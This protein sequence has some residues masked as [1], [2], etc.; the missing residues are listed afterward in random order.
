MPVNCRLAAIMSVA[1][2]IQA[3][4]PDLIN[5]KTHQQLEGELAERDKGMGAHVIN[6]IKFPCFVSRSNLEALRTFEVRDDDVYVFSYPRSGTHWMSEILHYILHDGK[7]DFNRSFMTNALEMTMAE[8]PTQLESVTPGYKMYAAMA[9]PR[10]I[11]SHCLESFRPPQILTKQ[12]KVVYVARNPKD[13]LVSLSNMTSDWKFDE[14]FWA[15]CKEKMLMGS[16][17]DHVLSYW[18]QRDKEHFLFVKYEDLHKDLRGSICKLAKHVGKDLSDDVIDD[19]L[20]RVTFGGMQKTY[21]QLEEER[22]EEGQRMTRYQGNPHLRRGKVGNWKNTFTVAQSALFDK[23]YALR[24]EGTGLDFDF[25][26]H[27][28]GVRRL[29]ATMS[30]A[31]RIQALMPDLI[32]GKTHQQLEEELAVS[33]KQTGCHVVNGTKFPWTISRSNLEALRTFEVRND[34]VYVFT[35]PRSGTHWVCEILQCIL[36]DV[37]GDFDRTF[38]TNALEMTMTDDPTHLESVAPGYKAYAGMASPRCIF[39]HCLDSFRPPQIL[40]KRAKVVYVARNPK[41]M[42]VSLFEMGAHWKFD[43]MFWAFCH[44]K[45][46]LGSWFDHVLNHRDKENFQFIKYEDLHKDL[47]GSICKLAQHVGKDLPD[48]VIDDILERVTFGGMQ[49]TYQQIEEERGEEGK[50]MTRYRGVFPYLRQGNVGNWKNT[51]TL[52]Q[53]ALFDKIYVLKMEG[54]GLDFDFEL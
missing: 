47:R 5:G 40:T 9:S 50:R 30:V 46:H 24:M 49:K 4:M 14:M 19:I 18:N 23:I 51:F 31:E 12:A 38:M 27:G 13:M 8:D 21:Q 17:F 35:Y 53:S 16:W 48:D 1:E 29:A 33:D 11:L 44:G 2:Q 39:S 42:L 36:Q 22:G 54:T 15:F 10:C 52:A 43:E 26:S 41:D 37:K 28:T 45:M 25:E 6:G 20:E 3:L 7:G 34:D 32:N